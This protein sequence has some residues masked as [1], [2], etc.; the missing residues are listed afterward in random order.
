MKISQIAARLRKVA[1][2]LDAASEKSDYDG[3]VEVA[4][5]TGCWR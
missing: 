3:F 5:R 2:D 1:S 4:A